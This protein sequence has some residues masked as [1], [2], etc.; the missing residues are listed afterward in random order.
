MYITPDLYDINLLYG[1]PEYSTKVNFY[2][3]DPST[4]NTVFDPAQMVHSG[5]GSTPWYE[6]K[7]WNNVDLSGLTANKQYIVRVKDTYGSNG[8][9]PKVQYVDFAK[10]EVLQ[11][12]AFETVLNAS[13]TISTV[14]TATDIDIDGDSNNDACMNLK[15]TYA[16]WEVNIA[17]G[18]YT[19]TLEY[20]VTNYTCKVKVELI[21]PLGVESPRELLYHV[22]NDGTESGTKVRIAPR[23]C[24]FLD[25]TENKVYKI[26]V[27]DAY[28]GSGCNLRVR[29]LSF[30]PFEDIR[31]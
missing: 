1:T 8:S 29:S 23:G 21:D 24:D 3:I 17:R 13:N 27:S 12:G 15:N 26:K 31:R 10:H 18:L 16:E 11:I 6:E 2:I 5:A 14:T 20:G 4:G 30:A 28:G 25:V 19:M 22:L 9:K 7:N